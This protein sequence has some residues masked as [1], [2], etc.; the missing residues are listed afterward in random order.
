MIWFG[1][2][3]VIGGSVSFAMVVLVIL[4]ICF[5]VLIVLTLLP[6]DGVK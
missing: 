3:S 1:K 4:I 6:N 5:L 2:G